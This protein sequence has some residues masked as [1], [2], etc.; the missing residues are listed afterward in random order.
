MRFGI[1]VAKQQVFSTSIMGRLNPTTEV[2]EPMNPIG[3]WLIT[4]CVDMQIERS[5]VFSFGAG[6][7][8]SILYGKSFQ[9]VSLRLTTQILKY[10]WL[11]LDIF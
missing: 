5:R 8:T 2:V 6:R 11:L 3:R 7:Q 9:S 10:S 1:I 4:V